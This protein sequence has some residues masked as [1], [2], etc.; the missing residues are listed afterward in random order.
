VP[1]QEPRLVKFEGQ[2]HSFPADFTDAEISA[3]LKAIP[4][5]NSA[6]VPKA[7]T[8]MSAT[9]P[10][11][12]GALALS[13]TAEEHPA[14]AVGGA[15]AALAAGSAPA[16]VG[17]GVRGLAAAAE[18]VSPDVVG[19]YSPRI[20]HAM[21]L[22]TKMIAAG[23]SAKEVAPKLKVNAVDFGRIKDLV[24]QGVSQND[25]VQAVLNLRA[26]GIR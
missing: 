1:E 14:A 24:A 12:D 5:S 9:V 6:A 10:D 7:K 11:P 20:A 19:L 8:W 17:M 23:K 15:T 22:A 13:E 26:K 21:R 2:V 25:A 4:K 16:L 18:Y 3:A